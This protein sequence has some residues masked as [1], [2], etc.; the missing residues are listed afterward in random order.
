MAQ[1]DKVRAGD[2][3]RLAF[4]FSGLGDDKIR[5]VRHGRVAANSV[6]TLD[7]AL[8]R[9]AVIVPAHRVKH[10]LPEHAT[11]TGNGVNLNVTKGRPQVKKAAD[12]RG[13]SVDGENLIARF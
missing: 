9:Q 2:Y 3:P 12:G 8:R 6:M 11:E 13:R 4:C 1:R 7:T 10:H 5:V